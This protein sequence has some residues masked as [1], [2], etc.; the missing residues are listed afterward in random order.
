MIGICRFLFFVLLL[1]QVNLVFGQMQPKTPIK[2]PN[3]TFSE[4]RQ[5]EMRL[6]ERLRSAPELRMVSPISGM[7]YTGNSVVFEWMYGRNQ[8]IFLGI[9]DNKNREVFYQ[10]VK[11]SRLVVPFHKKGFKPGLYYYVLENEEDIL[12]VGKF[13][14]KRK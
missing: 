3:S 13:F 6:N 9:L 11:Y 2:D 8:K 4:N 5:W 10:E 7:N 14:S 1:L 12:A